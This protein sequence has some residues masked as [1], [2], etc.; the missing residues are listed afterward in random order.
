ML[1]MQN[2]E[3]ER[4]SL[5]P[6]PFRATLASPGF[7]VS[8]PLP[9]AR[10]FSPPHPY[11]VTAQPT[12]FGSNS[13]FKD[14]SSIQLIL[15]NA[16]LEMSSDALSSQSIVKVKGSLDSYVAENLNGRG[17]PRVDT[18][19]YGPNAFRAASP[20][21][22]SRPKIPKAEDID[23]TQVNVLVGTP[24]LPPINITHFMGE[25]QPSDRRR[26]QVI[27]EWLDK[28]IKGAWHDFQ[29]SP[30]YL[31]KTIR[32]QFKMEQGIICDSYLDDGGGTL[33]S[34]PYPPGYPSASE[35]DAFT[36][37][38]H[39]PPVSDELPSPTMTPA[40]PFS[41]PVGLKPYAEIPI[42]PMFGVE[43]RQ[44]SPSAFTRR[45]T[46]DYEA[47]FESVN[48][49]LLAST[50]T[51]VS[52]CATSLI[53]QSGSICFEEGALFARLWNLQTAAMDAA[54]SS[55]RKEAAQWSSE[56]QK[57]GDK[58]KVLEPLIDW[59]RDAKVKIDSL[60][61]DLESTKNLLALACSERDAALHENNKIIVH[62]RKELKEFKKKQRRDAFQL[63]CKVK[64]QLK[65]LELMQKDRD[66]LIAAVNSTKSQVAQLQTLAVN[67]RTQ[68]SKIQQGEDESIDIDVEVKAMQQAL[69]KLNEM[70]KETEESYFASE[71]QLTLVSGGWL[72]A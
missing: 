30:I 45:A 28:R 29:S 56:A 24:S 57:L 4:T 61:S 51:S 68:V 64:N 35:A 14:P 5:P 21:R 23:S 1:T 16:A 50:L 67:L 19:T 54:L 63:A 20:S 11:T 60:S 3:D 44:S 8:S 31:D 40:H 13:V 72:I 46:N 6:L 9:S 55:S 38:P 48:R 42:S 10:G 17:G 2:K 71:E 62:Y 15:P 27:S 58:V 39:L 22:T 32:D 41:P 49:N 47:A 37:F 34:S 53:Q 12:G 43:S 66:Q 36:S 69:S 26:V 33:P 65:Q 18:S 59:E 7:E 25:K 52:A 70:V